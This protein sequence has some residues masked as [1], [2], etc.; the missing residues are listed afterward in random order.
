MHALKIDHSHLNS[1]GASPDHL[2]TADDYRQSSSPFFSRLPPE[3]RH[4]IYE[5][6]LHS[7]GLTQHIYKTDVGQTAAITHTRC[8]ID[9]DDPD[10]R[11]Q[12]YFET[13]SDEAVNAFGKEQNLY[14]QRL[15]RGRQYTDWCNHWQCEEGDCATSEDP[16][17]QHFS[18]FL[19]PLLT[20]RRMHSEFVGLLYSSITFSFIYTP[21]LRRFVATTEP[22]H[23]A[24]VR[25]LH[26][27]WCASTEDADG[28][29]ETLSDEGDA[30]NS[31]DAIDN[32]RNWTA[33]WSDLARRAPRLDQVRLW[34]YG[35]FP[36]FPMPPLE[37]FQALDDFA[38]GNF[39]AAGAEP[40]PRVM[41]EFTVRAV[42]TR[43]FD[44]VT[45]DGQEVQDDGEIVP[46]C[47]RGRRFEVSRV[48]A[49]DFEPEVWMAMWSRAH[50]EDTGGQGLGAILKGKGWG[51]RRKLLMGEDGRAVF[52]RT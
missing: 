18:A 27:I 45:V 26:L 8:L 5:A 19:S 4:Q 51:I 3:I 46:D 35:R 9:P 28:L 34:I 52:L 20:C 48:P 39:T 31:C 43:E 17:K 2:A 7:A 29:Q 41:N 49:V 14:N 42:W 40:V 30:L 36:R 33:L 16:E 21:A 11:E 50:L 47:L 32:P 22:R 6:L 25:S 38:D 15:W 23:L 44:T 24:L 10:L 13:F 37:Y 1:M 12:G